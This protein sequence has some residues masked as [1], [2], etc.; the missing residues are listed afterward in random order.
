MTGPLIKIC[1]V[2]SP[3]IA[4]VVAEQ[5]A[6]FMGLIFAPARRQVTE[7]QARRI[8]AGLENARSVILNRSE[9][10]PS[11]FPNAKPQG[12]CERSFAATHDD[13]GVT[14]NN[15]DVDA[16]RPKVVG[17]FVNESVDEMNR[18]ADIVGLDFIQLSGDEPVEVQ[19]A[20][21][22]PVIRALRLPIGITPAEAYEQAEIYLDCAAP[23]RA[24]LLDTHVSGSYGGNGIPGDWN[25]ARALAERYPVLLAGGLR[26]E[27]V[28][29]AIRTVRPFGVDVSSG[30]ETEGAKDPEKI[31]QFIAA[32]RAASIP[33][34]RSQ[35]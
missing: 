1:G 5:G 31:R 24:L 9:E 2:R 35:Q 14:E 22:Q 20:L 30:V 27:T 15:G 8:V 18:L 6:D 33:A 11:R 28:D 34:G 25:V 26:P 17:V 10:S 23:A 7:E 16:R 4:R 29:E 21:K 12:T 19:G 32:A 3:E 13:N